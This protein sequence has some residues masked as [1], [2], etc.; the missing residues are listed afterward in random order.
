M[1]DKATLLKQAQKQ[2]SKGN[3]DKAIKTFDQLVKL[4]P[5][6]HRLSL[7]YAD[8]LS[9]AGRK[10]VAVEQYEKVASIYILDDFSPKAIAVYKT[11]LR[12]DP[13]HL[14]AYRKLAELYKS[15]GLESEALTQLQH[16]FEH[17]EKQEDEN[18][19]VEVLKLMTDLDPENLGFQVRLGETMAKMGKKQEAA[20]AF[21]HA[22]TT[23][24][25]RGFH[26]RASAL[27]E[28]IVSLNP[29]NVAVRK[30]LCSH[31][32]ESG[33]F[34][35]ARNEI[36]AIL[37]MEPDD[38]RMILLLGRI[39]FKLNDPEAGES[40]IGRSL[41]LFLETGELEGVLREYLFVAQNHL[42]SNELEEAEA[43]YR[44]IRKAVP[45]DERALKGLISVSDARRDKESQIDLTLSLAKTLSEKGDMAGA[46][47]A[48]NQLL[49]MDP[50]N[51]EALAFLAGEE[52][53]KVIDQEVPDTVEVPESGPE[54][55]TTPG[56][57]EP[58]PDADLRELHELADLGDE[59]GKDE[60][61]PEEE[62]VH[63]QIEDLEEAGA[64][65]LQELKEGTE[66]A[67]DDLMPDIVF[68]TVDAPEPEEDKQEIEDLDALPILDDMDIIPLTDEEEEEDEDA[69]ADVLVGISESADTPAPEPVFEAE[70]SSEAKTEMSLDDLV[71][72][73]QVY[74]RYGLN[75][76]AVKLLESLNAEHPGN[77]NVLE[78]LFDVLADTD[79]ESS[80]PPGEELVKALTEA[81]EKDKAG[82]VL[83][84]MKSLSAVEET[85]A[86]LSAMVPD[87]EAPAVSEP[88]TPDN[89]VVEGADPFTEELEEAEFYLSQG[90]E[91]EAQRIYSDILSKKPDHKVA[92]QGM[93]GLQRSEG[94]PSAADVSEILPEIPEVQKSEPELPD[95]AQGK[96]LLT[97]D[98]EPEPAFASPQAAGLQIPADDG[99]F[100]DV[101]S[102]LVVED[103]TPEVED[104]LDLAEE[105][106]TELADELGDIPESAPAPEGPV[107]FEEI[108]AQFKKGIAETI[109]DQEHETHYD[110]GIAYKEMGL[111]DDAIKEFEL[112]SHDPGLLLDSLS[113][114]AMCFSEKQ[115]YESAT[116][117]IQTALESAQD[118]NLPGLQFQLGQVM[119]K[120]SDLE[121]ALR[122]YEIVKNLD[123]SFEGIEAHMERVRKLVSVDQASPGPAPESI[124]KDQPAEPDSLDGMLDD[125]I[126]EVEEMAKKEEDGRKSKGKPP[127]KSKKDRIS[128]I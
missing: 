122:S 115:D 108:F 116:R 83:E 113:L 15:Q 78:P 67:D 74:R 106:R 28:K 128:Y 85:V 18:K 71:L 21:A 55:E 33:L 7:R 121:K 57:D 88:V 68:E 30:E 101:G 81:G 91:E 84:K 41:E 119:E 42:N 6:D 47:E 102:K 52:A 32:L 50:G 44:Q 8:L 118:S 87:A 35:E 92:L 94:Q 36:I 63:I 51:E 24:S 40:M 111:L 4:D 114:T 58:I 110:L 89:A 100:R 103:S 26:D 45:P 34:S 46:V 123:P 120:Q 95:A 19:Q 79:P 64:D 73:A 1:S 126:H 20:E 96:P 117:A 124:G 56:L 104:F 12:L 49:E 43:F 22:A 127:E 60:T 82:I 54:A 105:L 17:F 72:E 93:G 86:S 23:L 66:D 62:Q 9:R 70:P 65:L 38:P 109:G 112:A 37:E 48:F 53:R 76:K 77:I 61:V 99:P 125:L 25:K 107:T 3:I 90:M 10:K 16:L 69:L 80:I 27:F 31:Y 14:D 59:T 2:L 97:D 5:K 11:I 29:E 13:D 39:F 75:D 98:L